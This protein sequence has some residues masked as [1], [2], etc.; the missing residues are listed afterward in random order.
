MTN[1]QTCIKILYMRFVA[2]GV[3]LLCLIYG[4][5]QAQQLKVY[6]ID[7]N[8]GSSTLIVSPTNKYILIDAGMTNYGNHTVYPFLTSL[9]I[10]HLDHTIATHYHEDHI[11]GLDE[12]I[13]A[14]SGSGRNDSVLGWCYDRGDSNPPVNTIYTGYAAAAGSKR[15]VIGLGETLNLGGG[16]FMFCVVRNGRVMN[17]TGVTPSSGE[18]HRSI[19]V[20]LQYGRFRLFIGGD[21]TGYAV[22]G[23]PDVETK[24]APVTRDVAVYVVNHHGSRNSSNTVFLDS[25]R[26]KAAIISQG[27]IPSNNGHPHQEALDRLATRN[28]Y[29]YQ[30]NNNPSG[31]T[32]PAGYGRI[33]NTTA[34]VT[35]NPASFTINGDEYIPSGVIRDATCLEIIS[36]RDTVTETTIITPKA[37]IKN[38]GNTTESFRI[39]FRIGDG[40]NHTKTIS[41][42]APGDTVTVIFDTMWYAMRGNYQTVCSTEV[43]GDILPTNDKKT[44]SLTVAYY[45]NQILSILNPAS[46]S[47]FYYNDTITPK[48]IIKDNSEYSYPALI[49]VFSI[50]KNNSNIIYNDSFEYS[51]FSGSIDTITFTPYQITNADEGVYLCSVWVVRNNDLILSNNYLVTQFNIVNPHGITDENISNHNEYNKTFKTAILRLYNISGQLLNTQT[52]HNPNAQTI[53]QSLKLTNNLKPGIYFI[54]TTTI[55]LD[56]KYKQGKATRKIV[57]LPNN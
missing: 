11:G 43:Y 19:G 51:S 6:C 30:M 39:R 23:D 24:V 4:L 49:K 22:S 52:I 33:L 5:I 3:L 20:I 21:L 7:V 1:Y 41:N 34:V 44:A 18:N 15:R 32:I 26:A 29:I 37:L 16:A 25:L 42:L 54:Q 38:L 45:D 27:T 12:V 8:T 48:V 17:G 53:H 36:P 35:I 50:I 55:P 46:S 14:L 57:I 31:G 40:Y 2:K 13:Y 56:D 47:V 10:T 28:T 9:G